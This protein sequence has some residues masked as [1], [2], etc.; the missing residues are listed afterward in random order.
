MEIEDL[1]RCLSCGEV[2][3]CDDL[4]EKE[5][6]GCYESDYGVYDQFNSHTY[7]SG[8]ELCCPYCG[9]SEN[10]INGYMCNDCEN[11]VEYFCDDHYGI[12]RECVEKYTDEEYELKYPSN[13]EEV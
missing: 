1:V 11:F 4:I 5:I 7:Y 13:Y 10:L 9:D 6:S 12:C 3:P 2:F 8:T